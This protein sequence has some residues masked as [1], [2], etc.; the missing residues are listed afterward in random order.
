MMGTIELNAYFDRLGTPRAGRVLVEKARREAPVRDIQ[1]K[2]GNVITWLASSKM[3]RPIGAESRTGEYHAIVQYEHDKAA[4]EFY[5]Q[6]C[7]FDLFLTDDG[8]SK[9]SRVQHTPDI[10][11]LRQEQI[12]IEE[13]KEESRLRKLAEKSPGRYTREDDGWH[14]PELEKHLLELGITYRLRSIEEHPLLYIRNIRFLGDYLHPDCPSVGAQAISR[15]RRTFAENSVCNLSDLLILAERSEEANSDSNAIPSQDG[16]VLSPAI[17][18]D[19]IYKAIADRQITFDFHNDDIAE[20][21]R[22]RVFRD[23]ASMLFH[24]MAFNSEQTTLKGTLSATICTGAKLIYDGAPYQIKLVGK[25]EVLVGGGSGDISIAIGELVKLHAAGKI[26]IIPNAPP[27]MDVNETLA[28]FSPRDLETAMER[29]KLLEIEKLSPGTTSKS[30][31]TLQRYREKMRKA[32]DNILQ[33]HM[34]LVPKYANCGNTTRKIPEAMIKL[35]DKFVS[36]HYNTPTNRNRANAFILFI[37]ECDEESVRPCSRKTFN[38]EIER[39]TSV[40]GRQGKRVAYQK[41]PIVWYLEHKEPIHGVRPHEYVHIDH[42]RLDIVL[43]GF[44]NGKKVLRGNPWLS[45]A[46]DA[47]SRNVVGYYLSFEAPSYRSNMMVL[48][49]IVRRYGRMPEMLI[50]DNGKDFHAKAFQRVC[51]LYGT[52]IRFRPAAQ[53]RHGSVLERMFGT[54]NTELIHNLE[55]NTQLMKYVRTV[56]KSVNPNNFAEWT[57]PA[58]HGGL[59][60]FFKRLYGTEIHPAHGAEPIEHFHIRMV[61]TGMRCHRLVNF[62]ERFRI[63]TC[64]APKD[65]ETRTVDGQRGVKINHIWYWSDKLRTPDQHGTAIDVRVDPWDVRIVFA[66]VKNEWVRCHSKLKQQMSMYTEI[67]VR[68]AFEELAKKKGIKKKDLTPERIAEWLMVMDASNFDARLR[69]EQSD[70]RT[71]YEALGMAAV[72]PGPAVPEGTAPPAI[73]PTLTGQLLGRKSLAPMPLN[74]NPSI[75]ESEEE[76]ELL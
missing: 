22:V 61:E 43:C 70:A 50:V 6:P 39:R 48:R 35:F 33:Q 76:Y 17:T 38:K 72:A 69:E 19:D 42:T 52:S 16:E 7:A 15:I 47:E 14:F 57:L 46:M 60:Y 25:D 49:D 54:I 18:T 4:L 44:I 71:I 55:G 13:W 23:E 36:K 58:L 65:K 56:T 45:L 1:S 59:D 41:Q 9:P 75:E 29:A 74:A 73:I 32:G 27:L 28:P 10:L 68:T 66:L 64:P 63:E 3:G 53:P 31:R 51:Q 12:L 20:T 11:I 24:Q 8:H 5:T 40:R 62:D 2:L 34:A 21:H 26:T 30:R 67:E 37:K